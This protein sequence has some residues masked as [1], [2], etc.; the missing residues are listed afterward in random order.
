MNPKAPGKPDEPPAAAE[1][2]AEA[3]ARSSS[4]PVVGVGASAGGFEAFTQ[5]LQHLPAQSGMA[6]VL[7][8]HLDP[9]HASSLVELLA[10]TTRMPVHQVTDGT[11]VEED[12]VYVIPPN[13]DMVIRQESLR[14]TPRTETR[15]QHMPV[16]GFLRSLAEERA[17][18]AIG[19]VLSGTGSDG[20]LGLKAIKAEGGIT[21]A[22][23]ASAKYDGMPRSAI[24]AGRGDFVLPPEGIAAELVRIGQHPYV[25]HA[26]A[27]TPEKLPA[28]PEEVLHAL[29]LLLRKATG[30]DFANYKR[31]TVNRRVQ[32]RMV[33]HRLER[34]QDYVGFFQDN[35]A[36]VGAVYQDILLHLANLF[37]QPKNLCAHATAG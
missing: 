18:Q 14:L 23:D 33:L 9:K 5:L 31:G 24:G 1:G 16:D 11:P 26:Q 12:Q 37:R 29:F 10:K 25:N 27:A 35:P 17:S 30:V 20:T 3:P 4:F 22:Q 2:L 28:E 8:Q 36:E 34:L 7:V 21:F 19:V 15:G 13:T 6:F 32:R